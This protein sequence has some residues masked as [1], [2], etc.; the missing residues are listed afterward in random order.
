MF[1]K[2]E[3]GSSPSL[4]S[5]P[6]TKKSSPISPPFSS[7]APTKQLKLPQNYVTIN[8]KKNLDT[9]TRY[10]FRVEIT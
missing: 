3:D 5:A 7:P 8:N 9:V 1:L 2:H 10:V 6:V 4:N